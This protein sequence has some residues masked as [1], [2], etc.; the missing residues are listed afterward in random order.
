MVGS[1][2]PCLPVDG[3]VEL[4]DRTREVTR[5]VQRETQPVAGDE[6][7]WIIGTEGPCLPVYHDMELLEGLAQLARLAQCPRQRQAR[8]QGEWI[9]GAQNADCVADRQA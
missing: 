9:V 4:L 1:E 8:I 2:G 3:G 7:V 5:L 6:G